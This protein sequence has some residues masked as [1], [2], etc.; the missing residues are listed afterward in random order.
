LQSTSGSIFGVACISAVSLHTAIAGAAEDEHDGTVSQITQQLA[1]TELVYPQGAL[2]LQTS[3]LPRWQRDDGTNSYLANATV[4]FGITDRVELDAEIP[5]GYVGDPIRDGG[6][7]CIQLQGLFNLY[8]S[9]R[10]GVA[11]STGLQIAFPPINEHVGEQF[12]EDE[13]ELEPF[14]I[15]YY[16]HGP[17]G[18]NLDA[19]IETGPDRKAGFEK[20]FFDYGAAL[21][22][23]LDLDPF[24]LGAEG[25]VKV[26]TS[27]T[28][29]QI[30]PDLIY[31]PRK[32]IYL[33]VAVPVGLTD[34]APDVA[35]MLLLTMEHEFGGDKD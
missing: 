2:E 33:G 29:V 34:P 8:N 5:G 32:G 35:V 17:V 19:E 23:L 12:G 26:E 24:A 11:F 22:V 28:S 10:R 9:K 16:T 25:R 13:A 18:F 3:L 4:E 27:E 21:A 20:I 1:L 6:V 30:A 31:R 7:G 14:V 15:G